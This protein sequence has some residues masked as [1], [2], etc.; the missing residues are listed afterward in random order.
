MGLNMSKLNNRLGILFT[1]CI[2]V[3]AFLIVHPSIEAQEGDSSGFKEYKGV[4]VNARTKKALEYAS[5]SVTNSN[6]STITNLEGVFLV[7][8]PNTLKTKIWW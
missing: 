1:S 6:I 5:I 2:Y 8:V 7:K 4:V 3:I